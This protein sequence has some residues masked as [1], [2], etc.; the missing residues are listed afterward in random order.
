MPI[1]KPRTAGAL[2]RDYA[3]RV[4]RNVSRLGRLERSAVREI[5]GILGDTR[6]TILARL[7][8]VPPDQWEAFRL[9]ELQ[10]A[11]DDALGEF[12]SRYGEAMKR[13]TDESFKLG[14]VNATEPLEAVLRP[15]FDVNVSVPTLPPDLLEVLQ[16]TT[17]D[18]VKDI[19]E[20]TRRVVNEEVRAAVLGFK[21]PFEAQQEIAKKLSSRKKKGRRSGVGFDAERIV[22]T[23]V[24][25]VFSVANAEALKKSKEFVPDLKKQWLTANDQRVRGRPGGLYP[26]GRRTK[27]DH[28]S[29]HEEVQ[30]MDKKFSNGLRFPRDP[31]GPPE[32]VILC[33]LP[34][35]QVS[36]EFVAG[37]KARYSGPAREI[38]T[39]RGYRL[40][41]SANHPIA[42]AKG[43]VPAYLLR[44]GDDL[45][46]YR[47]EIGSH[48]SRNPDCEDR[49]AV[50]EDVFETLAANGTVRFSMVGSLDFHGDAKFFDGDVEI[51]DPDRELRNGIEADFTQRVDASEFVMSDP[52]LAAIHAVSDLYFDA[53]RSFFPSGGGPGGGALALDEGTVLLQ[54]RPFDELRLGPAA[55]WNAPLTEAARENKAAYSRFVRE[56]LHAGA[57]EVA[58]D[59]IVKIRDFD[60]WGHVYD[61]QTVT[62]WILAGGIVSSNCRC[63]LLAFR[64]EWDKP[65]EERGIVA[66]G[67][68]LS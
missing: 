14:E 58:F 18:L 67:A 13:A 32:Q 12:E 33:F 68:T 37:S 45:L 63:T 42:T 47:G 65:V 34:G 46:S 30:P 16:G 57:G 62:G 25:R 29:L 27:G 52:G 19:S 23:E 35:T 39:R 7:A 55:D 28:W 3:R 6:G 20:R 11:V 5:E 1:G 59:E 22:R 31:A 49:P 26:K 66:G 64:D 50:I 2:R 43:F 61:L 10:A 36:G 24:N 56:L 44:K 60:F 53:S 51:V 41:V 54:S 8:S 21:R 48:F 4:D 9:G 17:A 40:R 15:Q 38:E